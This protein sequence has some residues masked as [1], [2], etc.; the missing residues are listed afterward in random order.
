MYQDKQ[1]TK[2]STQNKATLYH[3]LNG[4]TD[5]LSVLSEEKI[6]QHIP[7]MRFP[8]GVDFSREIEG[9]EYIVT[10]HFN[11]DAHEAIYNKIARM[12]RTEV[13]G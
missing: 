2:P 11:Q 10:S 9:T 12:L 6:R 8:H 4:Y 5:I 13:M 1:N 3:A 7:E